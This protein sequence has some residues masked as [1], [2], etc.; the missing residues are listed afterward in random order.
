MPFSDLLM[1]PVESGPGDGV[2]SQSLGSGLSSANSR[3]LVTRSA[4][5][6][7]NLRTDLSS[8]NSVPTRSTSFEHSP[9]RPS[10][11]NGNP[12]PQFDENDPKEIIL[13]AFLPKVAVYASLDTEELVRLKG[14]YGGFRGLL[15]PFGEG[16][17]GNVVIRDSVGGSKSWDNF[18][19]HFIEFDGTDGRL[20]WAQKSDTETQRTDSQ[21]IAKDSS[22]S[23]RSASTGAAINHCLGLDAIV[24]EY[25]TD[26]LICSS[27]KKDQQPY[28][29]F[30]SPLGQNLTPPYYAFYLR[31]LLSQ[32]PMVPHET[33]SQPVACVI[34]ISSQCQRPIE[35][36][37]ELYSDT[38]QGARRVPLWA[39]N[40]FLRYYVL[41]HDEDH[42]D[43]KKSTSLFDQMKKHFGL[44]CHLLRLR[45]VE[46]TKDE[47]DGTGLPHCQWLSAEEELQHTRQGTS[48]NSA[49]IG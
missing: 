9:N 22:Q 25:L 11:L 28:T 37:R 10:R 45:S 3:Y 43:I 38:R 2:G 20:S 16:L 21:Y 49:F 46:C 44:H 26:E 40:E 12:V 19:I 34:A 32:R 8:G 23:S 48:V 24:E 7:P 14:V 13:K 33:F 41:I 31:K 47:D 6:E 1:L 39:G 30:S 18:G 4:S 5:V 35:T 36:L 42:D 17:P 27:G 15:R 29:T